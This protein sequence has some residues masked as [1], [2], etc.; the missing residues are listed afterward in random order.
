[1]SANIFKIEGQRVDSQDEFARLEEENSWRDL[2]YYPESF[3]SANRHPI[4]FSEKVFERISFK[5]TDF[6]NIRFLRCQFKQCLFAGASFSDCEF[7]DCRFFETNTSKLRVT[8][9][10]LDPKDFKNNFDLIDDTNI[11]I[12]LYQSLYKN[13]SDEHQPDHS[14]E[15]L[16]QM[17]R[18]KH[19]HLDSQKK[20]NV[21]TRRE[22]LKGKI[23]HWMYD[24]V[25]GY[26]LRPL[27]VVRL[28]F[29]VVGLF[30]TLNFLFDSLIF[31]E[32][33]SLSFVDSIYFT[34][35]AITTLGF[36]DIVPITTAGRVFVTFQA[37]LGFVAMSLFL[38]AIVNIA[39][40]SR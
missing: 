30:S 10:L 19:A 31:G 8:R 27:R 7:I 40:R 36:G 22:Y 2:L 25:T 12:G 4:V 5:D 37:L 28:L 24:F 1:M 32:N 15:S 34:V 18:A 38:S 23:R 14:I 26:G 39:L 20:R 3:Q 21:I 13:A 17:E 29:I 35:V 16:Y 9:C 33:G 11:A 6:R